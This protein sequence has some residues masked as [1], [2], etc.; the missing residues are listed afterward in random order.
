MGNS[1]TAFIDLVGRCGYVA[2]FRERNE[3]IQK[4]GGE[5]R[6]LRFRR[7]KS[8]P[9]KLAALSYSHS[10]RDAL[11]EMEFAFWLDNTVHQSWDAS[12]WIDGQGR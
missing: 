2:S 7:G 9:T 10:Q 1:S 8:F 11:D 4:L 5:L 6:S 3:K 12:Y